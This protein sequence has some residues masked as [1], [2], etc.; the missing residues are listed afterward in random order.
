MGRE[1]IW[2]GSKS[3]EWMILN[4]TKSNELDSFRPDSKNIMHVIQ[5]ILNPCSDR[6]P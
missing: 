3:Q 6:Q 5:M 2:N 1:T 4:Q